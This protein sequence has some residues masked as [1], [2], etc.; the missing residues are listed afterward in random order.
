M[1]RCK[2]H[3]LF[4]TVIRRRVDHMRCRCIA[5]VDDSMAG[6]GD[7]VSVRYVAQIMVA[8][9]MVEDSLERRLLRVHPLDFLVFA[10]SLGGAFVV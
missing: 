3:K 1:Q 7:A 4:K 10:D 2:V 9:Q 6:V 5:S 8:C